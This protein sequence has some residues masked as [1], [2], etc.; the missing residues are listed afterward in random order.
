MLYVITGG[1]G[2]IGSNI[3]AQIERRGLGPVAII[4][5]L[6]GTRWLNIAERKLIDL[7]APRSALAY[8]ASCPDDTVVIHMGA[9]TSTDDDDVDALADTNVR[10]TVELFDLCAKRSWPFVYA[11]SASVYGSNRSQTEDQSGRDLSPYAWSKLAA[12]RMV[13]QRPATPPVWAGLR[14]FNVYGLNEQHKGEMKSF[15]SR[16][17]DAIRFG[18]PI[19]VFRGSNQFV[20]D[21]VYAEDVARLVCDLL[22]GPTPHDYTPK[23]MAGVYNVGTGV[24]ASFID[25]AKACI[26]ASGKVT[27]LET[28]P[29]PEAMRSRYQAYTKADT[30]KLLR[31]VPG[32]SFTP[33][34]E[35]VGAYWKDSQ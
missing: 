13:C 19:R 5:T 3:V 11:S 6:D 35:G 17:F 12:D 1:A 9:R 25:V 33:L 29:F 15:V 8:V 32:F 14:L 31:I 18:Q 7:I 20:R 24:A 30:A 28:A 23:A 21:W 27:P 4:D 34:R 26:E 2:F 16:C 10:L 22:T